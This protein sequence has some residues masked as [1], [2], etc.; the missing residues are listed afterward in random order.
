MTSSELNEY[1]KHYLDADK[2]K[3]AIMLTG[4]W[5]SGKSHYI[6]NDLVPFLTKEDDSKCVVVSLYGLTDLSEVSKGIYL[7]MRLKAIQ[8]V[9]KS[10]KVGKFF[11]KATSSLP[12]SKEAVAGGGLVAKTLIKGVTG[13]WG[14]DL[15]ASGDD[16]QKLYE[17]VDLSGKLII[18]E[19][20]ERSHIDILELLGYVNNLVEQDGIKV[21]LVSNEAELLEYEEISSEEDTVKKVLPKVLTKESMQYLKTKEK[22]VSDTITFT[23]DYPSAIRNI[24]DGFKDENLSLFLEE[25]YIQEV[26]ELLVLSKNGNLR[27]FIYACQKT[28]DILSSIPDTL[29]FE[30]KRTIFYS[31][32]LFSKHIK[33][34]EF[35]QW[36]GSKHLSTKLGNNIFPLYYFC[37]EYIRWQKFDVNAVSATIAEHTK[38]KLYQ[39]H[40]HDA[41]L[42]TL[43]NYYIQP[44][45]AV[46]NALK[47]I[48]VKLQDPDFIPFYEYGNLAYYFVVCHELLGFDYSDAKRSMITNI[49]EKGSEIDA[50]IL[51]LGVGELENYTQTGQFESFR[52]DILQAIADANKEDSEITYIPQDI[53]DYYA[54]IAKNKMS[55]RSKHRYLSALDL[56]KLET[57]I[58]SCTAEQLHD[59]RGVLFAVY[60][61]SHKGDF[62]EADIEYLAELKRRIEEK[63]A[64]DNLI[65][66]RIVLLQLRYLCDNLQ[67][68]VDQLS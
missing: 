6:N 42:N 63:M 23:G 58:F 62:I 9:K 66:D 52:K 37:Y 60:R 5:G 20:I 57:M 48:T 27:T 39:H 32:I 43:K 19:D 10:S 16:L 29:E 56:D 44:E 41:D 65:T 64:E 33:A 36:D 38:V 31:I 21:L 12:K 25:K 18:L 14:I 67:R 50:D 68:F 55:L 51:F 59:V 3:S 22:T 26:H 54:Y 53:S 61:D 35:P 34:G 11:E 47:N 2:T 7:D 46:L 49:R 45:T 28:A 4:S 24:I 30:D 13:L 15:S 8:K 1:I 40:G 17:S